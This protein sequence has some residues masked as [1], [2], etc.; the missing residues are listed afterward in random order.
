MAFVRKTHEI[1]EKKRKKEHIK[2]NI[3][4]PNKE[5][6][7]YKIIIKVNLAVKKHGLKLKINTSRS[8]KDND[9]KGNNGF[10]AKLLTPF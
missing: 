7:K 10:L 4:P 9:D 3:I 6:E 1:K 8:N 2:D 5:R